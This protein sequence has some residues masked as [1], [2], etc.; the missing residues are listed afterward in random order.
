MAASFHD[1]AGDPMAPTDGCQGFES[2]NYFTSASHR[3]LVRESPQLASPYN[4]SSPVAL[5]MLLAYHPRIMFPSCASQQTQDDDISP[6]FLFINNLRFPLRFAIGTCML[7][8]RISVN[9]NLEHVCS[10][11]TVHQSALRLLQGN[12][13]Y[14]YL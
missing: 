8:L 2:T 5:S 4:P 6:F 12:I 1:N 14:S 3:L 7:Q 10:Q 9:K 13:A 11:S